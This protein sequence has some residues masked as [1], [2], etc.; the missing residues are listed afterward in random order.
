MN[1]PFLRWSP[2]P[3]S[4]GRWAIY[5]PLPARGLR[6]VRLGSARSSR[7]RPLHRS[8][9]P[10]RVL[11]QYQQPPR[12]CR[13]IRARLQSTRSQEIQRHNEAWRLNPC[14]TWS[15]APKLAARCRGNKP[16]NATSDRRMWPT[17]ATP[18]QRAP[19]HRIARAARGFVCRYATPR[20]CDSTIV[21]WGAFAISSHDRMRWS[22]R[23]PQMTG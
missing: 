8:R 11:W 2:R 1:I 4:L 6:A 14:T 9:T 20:F 23:S 10:R 15:N 13:R 3:R 22:A 21:S 18:A 17:R 7:K 16:R 5:P 12:R 19:W